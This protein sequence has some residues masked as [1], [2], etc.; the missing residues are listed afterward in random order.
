MLKTSL[1][2]AGF[3]VAA[4]SAQASVFDF[5]DPALQDK[6]VTSV[7]TSDGL[8]TANLKVVA[9]KNSQNSD[10]DEALVFDTENGADG[11]PDLQSAFVSDLNPAV[12]AN[13][14]GVLVIAENDL[15]NGQ[16]PDDNQN[17]G[18][19]TFEFLKAVDFSGFTIYDDANITVTSNLGGSVSANV[20]GDGKFSTF[21]FGGPGLNGVTSLTFDFGRASGAI[22]DIQVSLS[23]VPLP[24]GLPLLLAG[25]G[26]FA[27][28][29]RRAA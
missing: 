29:R 13:A 20:V 21:S 26:G 25:L 9:N 10:V 11:D 18:S 6:I 5:D 16:L 2:V 17:G 24:A 23:Q 27:L 3:A 22:D 28:L 1:L 7:T 12:T 4:A 15:S 14:G 19:I 8:I